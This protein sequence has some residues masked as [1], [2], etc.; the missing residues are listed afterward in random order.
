[1]SAP[2]RQHPSANP[3]QGP[4]RRHALARQSAGL[5]LRR[6][7][8]WLAVGTWLVCGVAT[9]CAQPDIDAAHDLYN[10][11]LQAAQRGHSREALD[12][13]SQALTMFQQLPDTARQQADCHKN[14]GTVLQS[15]DRTE[16]AVVHFQ[17]AAQR[18]WVLPDAERPR[19][20]CSQNLGDALASLLKYEEALEPYQQA[21]QLFAKL[22]GAEADQAACRG[23]LGEA[24]RS[25]GKDAEALAQHQ[26]ALTLY[27]ALPGSTRQQAGCYNRL[28]GALYGLGQHV[29]ARA[30][31]QQALK[32][33]ETLPD[34]EREQAVCYQNI[35]E[36]LRLLG[37][38][39]EALRQHEQ[40][41]Q[42]LEALPDT[43]RLQADCHANLGVTLSSLDRQD[44]ALVQQQQALK[45][46]QLFPATVRDQADCRQNLGVA[47]SSLGRHTEAQ[48]QTQQALEGYA[49]LQGTAREQVRCYQNLGVA[50]VGLGQYEEA[51][52]KHQQALQRCLD[53]PAEVGARADCY[54][55]L[56]GV[57]MS[58]GRLEEALAR[59]QQAL[60]L[61][62]TLS[63]TARQQAGCYA[64]RG[65][66]LKELGN[67]AEALG[68]MQEALRLFR[69]L[70]AAEREQAGCYQNVG[71]IL[72]SLGQYEEA[73]AQTRQALQCYRALEG[74]ALEQARCHQNLGG[75][76][77][78]LGKYPD[79]MAEHRLARQLF[80]TVQGSGRDQLA[81]WGN[82]GRTLLG[83]GRCS[84]AIT[85][86]HQA[87]SSVGVTLG[88]S[89]ALRQRGQ[90]GDRAQAL[91]LLLRAGALADAARGELRAR[92]HREGLF[93]QFVEV[94]PELTGL[95]V[96]LGGQP[97]VGG[98]AEVARW[99]RDPRAPS[100]NLE[101]AFHFADQGKGRA[102]D[103]A[104]RAR[105]TLRAARPDTRLLAA[106]RNLSQQISQRM[107]LQAE[108]PETQV[109]RQQHL[110]RELEELQQRRNLI[111]VA[112]KRTTLGSYVAPEFRQPLAM[113]AELGPDRAVLQYSIGE[114]E[115]WLLLLTRDGI[116][117]HRLGCE[118]RALPELRPFQQADSAQLVA[119]WQQ[120][121]GQIGLDGLVQ[122]AR[123]RAEDQGC[124][125]PQNRL[126]AGQEQAI[127]QRLGNRLLPASALAVLRQQQVRH[128]VVI[129]DGA[130]HYLPFAMLRLAGESGAPSRYLLEEFSVS[131]TPA[132]TTLETIRQQRQDRARKR[133]RERLPL[134]AFANPAYGSE[135]VPAV[136]AS[137]AGDD[138]FTRVRSIRRDYYAGG[139]L[140]LSA[141]PET[142]QE[143]LRV[144]ALFGQPRQVSDAAAVDPEARCLV[145]T[146]R[147]A[148]E[149]QAKKL[150]GVTADTT[151]GAQPRAHYRYLLFS[152]HGMA[153]PHRG[154]L[155]CVALSTPA[156]GSEEDG[157]L[158]AQE[159]LDLDL[160]TDLVMLSAC[161]TGL[162]RLRGGEGLV[163]LGG[164]FF[165]AGA[166]S[167]SASLWSVPSGPTGQ[168]VTEFFKQLRAGQ[169]DR[170]EALRQAQLTVMRS[171][172]RVDGRSADYSSP[173]CWAA[174]VLLGEYR[175]A[176]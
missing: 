159:V 31:L 30:Q 172:R 54:S 27:Q 170:D 135:G 9:R 23:R 20:R 125:V 49:S 4:T 96:E 108:V 77:N 35:G 165:V 117:A 112:L 28:G 133:N 164:A 122:L 19:A 3:A 1:M 92:E 29:E 158:Q 61:Y 25:L 123:A 174:F 85:A 81:C 138:L 126:D 171:G 14:L 73:L 8:R 36:A 15:L 51:L 46:Y 78:G 22:P 80:Q 146:S 87:G 163:G 5:D 26:Q 176:P 114:H 130:L 32:L 48:A 154:L 65:T 115:N 79:A 110:T 44:E 128:L 119:A 173:F 13:W 2:A 97:A 82:L 37:N 143:A 156:P 131:Y 144:A 45:L 47:L 59:T 137:G 63:G 66:V 139:G 153:D 148:S 132:L 93:E 142:E 38:Y 175:R 150:L 136:R 161:Q 53:L 113:A 52:A 147:A 160:D 55:N 106:D 90:P 10:R 21:L 57:L 120:R 155:S 11:A 104:L 91:Q 34:T 84:E 134:L 116:S 56:G 167:I 99:A 41:L 118:T 62:Q 50:L 121:P 74:T 12:G 124:A 70:Q 98:E 145:L 43:E 76:L 18:Y 24:L 169:L 94:F 72:L 83:T 16:E 100:A 68:Q 95:L 40:A 149:E 141:L 157:F 107:A 162:G 129:P 105:V 39:T 168:L 140:H 64:N 151:P 7:L 102:L 152:T 6:A 86:F 101:A 166:E 33:Y 89:Q 58:L 109:E 88:L 60:K 75:L 71:G 103:D 67:Y 111:E 42:R 17:Q 127:L 69:S